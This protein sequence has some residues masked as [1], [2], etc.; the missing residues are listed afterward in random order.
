MIDAH[1]KSLGVHFL[2]NSS[3]SKRVNF[4]DF[5]QKIKIRSNSKLLEENSEDELACF[6]T[7]NAIDIFH[8][9]HDLLQRSFLEVDER[10]LWGLFEVGANSIVQEQGRQQVIFLENI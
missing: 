4:L 8:E 1:E 10:G 2:K 9:A 7:G 5:S 6:V 3:F